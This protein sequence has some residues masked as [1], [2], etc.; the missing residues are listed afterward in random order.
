MS[1]SFDVISAGVP[2]LFLR[3]IQC[4]FVATGY[5]IS[6]TRAEDVCEA[7]RTVRR[8]PS[9]VGGVL[10]YEQEIYS[11]HCVTMK[12]LECLVKGRFPRPTEQFVILEAVV[13][14]LV[15][16]LYHCGL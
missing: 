8:S 12:K 2:L 7:F 3:A 13:D 4:P 5:T 16:T 11:M 9:S 14:D 15:V 6:S 10:V 1:E